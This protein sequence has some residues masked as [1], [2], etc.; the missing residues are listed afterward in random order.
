MWSSAAFGRF[1]LEAEVLNLLD[2]RTEV[3]ARD[4]LVNDGQL[5]TRALVDMAGY[6]LPGR[7][8]LVALSVRL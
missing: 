6:P 3:G 1:V 8:V 2:Q 5:A 4:A 7:M